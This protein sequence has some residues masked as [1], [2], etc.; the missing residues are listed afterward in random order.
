MRTV[1][2]APELRKQAKYNEQQKHLEDLE[3]RQKV[4]KLKAAEEQKKRME[5]ERRKVR[6]SI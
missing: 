3:R 2:A 1:T 6:R 4:L 5:A